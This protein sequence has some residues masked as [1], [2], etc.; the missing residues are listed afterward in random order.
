MANRGPNT[1]VSYVVASPALAATP[2]SLDSML[3]SI[4]DSDSDSD[5]EGLREYLLGRGVDVIRELYQLKEK[6]RLP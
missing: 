4:L 6:A 1:I 5:S 3:D 2:A